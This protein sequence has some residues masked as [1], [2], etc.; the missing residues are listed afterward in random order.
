MTLIQN[1]LCVCNKCI[2]SDVEQTGK[3]DFVEKPKSTYDTRFGKVA[4]L[5][6]FTVAMWLISGGRVTYIYAE[7]RRENELFYHHSQL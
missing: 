3:S 1:L 7:E 4:V 2:L 6:K 5:K